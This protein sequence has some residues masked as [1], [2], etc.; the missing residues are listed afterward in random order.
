MRL[1]AP[2][3]TDDGRKH[4]AEVFGTPRI[5]GLIPTSAIGKAPGFGA[6]E[7]ELTDLLPK[8]ARGPV[9]RMGTHGSRQLVQLGI[10]R[11]QGYGLSSFPGLQLYVG[12]MMQMGV[13]FD[14]DPFL[15]W[16]RTALAFPQ[17]SNGVMSDYHRVRALYYAAADYQQRVLGTQEAHLRSALLKATHLPLNSLPPA[18]PGFIDRMKRLLREIYPQRM[19]SAVADAVEQIVALPACP[20]DKSPS[21]KGLG[22]QVAVRFALGRGALNDPRF[23]HLREAR[24]NPAH[25]FANL[26]DHL[27]HELRERGWK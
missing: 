11:A 22:V 9:T 20:G 3:A 16:S 19:E 5:V 15:P 13:D 27:T 7:Q 2:S 25:L 18:G 17:P 4:L 21:G 8:L 26:Q 1:G 14:D 10:H 24:G 23:P 12:L 6:S